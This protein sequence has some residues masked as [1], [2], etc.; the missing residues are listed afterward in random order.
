LGILR[1]CAAIILL[2]LAS[3]SLIVIMH[4]RAR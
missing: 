4:R 2:K 1:T 3:L